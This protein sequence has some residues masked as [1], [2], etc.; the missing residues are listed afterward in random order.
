MEADSASHEAFTIAVGAE[1]ASLPS[2]QGTRGC[3][4]VELGRLDQGLA[5][6]HKAIDIVKNP[7]EIAFSACFIALGE[8]RQGRVEESKRYVEK[9]RQVYPDCVVIPR[10]DHE[11]D[12][13]QLEAPIA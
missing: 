12:S 8:A 9:A 6:L 1:I 2:F 4:L 3:V 7:F 5:L 10:V 11:L 13:I